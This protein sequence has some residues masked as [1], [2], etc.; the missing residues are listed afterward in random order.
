MKNKSM[1]LVALLALAGTTSYAIAMPEPQV[2][3]RGINSVKV[4]VESAQVQQPVDNQAD[5]AGNP[6][7]VQA[8]D[9][10]S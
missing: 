6:D 5:D 8:T 9:S 10:D 3:S 2:E 7:Q 4:Q 1:I